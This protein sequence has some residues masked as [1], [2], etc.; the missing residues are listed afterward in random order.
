MD[1]DNFTIHRPELM[2]LNPE[3]PGTVANSITC[4]ILVHKP[5]LSCKIHIKLNIAPIDVKKK[6]GGFVLMFST[7]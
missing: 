5:G 7:C 3:F 1:S 2:G 6:F 4:L